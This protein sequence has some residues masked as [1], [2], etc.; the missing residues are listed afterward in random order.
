MIRD[1]HNL[2]LYIY[3][4]LLSSLSSIGEKSKRIRMSIGLYVIYDNIR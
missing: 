3:I 1:L 4:I 2:L